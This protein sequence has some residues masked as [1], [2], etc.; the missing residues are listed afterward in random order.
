MGLDASLAWTRPR[1]TDQA[2]QGPY[3]ANAVQKVANLSWSWRQLGAWSGSLGLRYIGSAP[4]LEDNSVRSAPSTTVKLRVQRQV[5]SALDVALDV[6]NL[7]QRKNNDIAYFYTSRVAGEAVAGVAD[8]HVHPAEPRTL[9]LT[10]R[11]RF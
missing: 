1:Y 6:L 7:T 4:L 10:A 3:M 9:R 2:V 5:S 11:L 8:V